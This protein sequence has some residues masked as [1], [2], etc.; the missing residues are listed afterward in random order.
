MS[1]VTFPGALGRPR[2]GPQPIRGRLSMDK[3]CRQS[4][5]TDWRETM[6]KQP[7]PRGLLTL[8]RA[9]LPPDVVT[10]DAAS[11]GRSALSNRRSTWLGPISQSTIPEPNMS[12]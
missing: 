8:S 5:T 7:V 9:A 3:H 11:P 4:K 12:P 2:T 10:R 1:I 6:A